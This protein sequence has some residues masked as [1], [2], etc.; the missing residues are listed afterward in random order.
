M[1]VIQAIRGTGVTTLEEMT[2]ALNQ[3]GNPLGSRREMVRFVGC[4]FS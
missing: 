2:Q 1:P 4:Q 3:R